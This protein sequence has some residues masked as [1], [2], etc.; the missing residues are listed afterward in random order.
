MRRAELQSELL[1]AVGDR[2]VAHGFV[3]RARDQA[4]KRKL[5]G[6]KAVLHLAF[7]PH[8]E[9]IDVTADVAVRLD[10]LEDL[11]NS[12]DEGIPKAYKQHTCSLGAELG[13]IESG[14]QRR[15]KISTS[16]EVPDMADA[17][18]ECFER[19][20]LPFLDEYAVPA[21][22][23][24]ALTSNDEASLILSPVIHYRAKRAVGL[25]IILGKSKG[26]VEQVIKAMESAMDDG[27]FQFELKHFKGFLAC[28][29]HLL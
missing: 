3:P 9:D 8:R 26:E 18:L 21:N 22:V 7:I 16:A 20:G 29:Q 4:F 13:N 15:W 2:V 1:K 25:A 6:G 28:I 10:A 5:E 17:I 19:V 24:R 23:F 11:L 27:R 14:R 12:C